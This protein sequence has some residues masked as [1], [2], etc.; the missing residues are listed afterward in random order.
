MLPR[1]CAKRSGGP[2][3]R[4]RTIGAVRRGRLR[5]AQP[6]SFD[7]FAALP[8][9]ERGRSSSRPGAGLRRRA[10]RRASAGRNWRI[11]GEPTVAARAERGWRGRHRVPHAAHRSTARHARGRALGTSS[12]PKAGDGSRPVSLLRRQLAR[13]GVLPSFAAGAGRASRDRERAAAILP[14]PT[15]ARSKRWPTSGARMAPELPD[16]VLRDG[17]E[18]LAPSD[19]ARIGRSSPAPCTSATAAATWA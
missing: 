5:P 17:A 14:S 3:G 10:L 13:A 2:G 7:D 19:R 18:K 12:D 16:A 8:P 15:R 6:F 11:D 4:R 1:G 9:L